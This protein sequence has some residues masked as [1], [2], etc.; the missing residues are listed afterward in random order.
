L[1]L[2]LLSLELLSLELLSLELLSLELLALELLSLELGLLLSLE[3]NAHLAVLALH[4][5]GLAELLLGER[6]LLDGLLIDLLW[7]LLRGPH[8]DH[9]GMPAAAAMARMASLCIAGGRSEKPSTAECDHQRFEGAGHDR[10]SF[11]RR[12]LGG[13]VRLTPGQ[14]GLSP[15]SVLPC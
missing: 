7:V 6:L 15:S 13:L 1:S 12:G 5:T 8:I 11:A 3:L 14:M 10:N 9:A 4:E 2:E